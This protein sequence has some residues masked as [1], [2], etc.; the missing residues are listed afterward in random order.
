M[1]VREGVG[2]A[3]QVDDAHAPHACHGARGEHGL[4]ERVYEH[5]VVRVGVSQRRGGG[6][7]AADERGRIERADRLGQE[8]W[9]EGL[10]VGINREQPLPLLGS[11]AE[12]LDAFFKGWL[13]LSQL[14][15]CLSLPTSFST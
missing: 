1:R 3:S 7:V 14:P 13:L 12:R 4:L 8:L 2:E 5:E 9:G 6:I 11:I 15:D 10:S